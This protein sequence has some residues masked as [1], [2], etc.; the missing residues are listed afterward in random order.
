MNLNKQ[1]TQWWS[2]VNMMLETLKG[3]ELSPEQIEKGMVTHIEEFESKVPG[4][5]VHLDF[6]DQ[7][8]LSLIDCSRDSLRT[9]TGSSGATILRGRILNTRLTAQVALRED[10]VSNDIIVQALRKMADYI[11]KMPVELSS[12]EAMDVFELLG[13]GKNQSAQ[14]DDVAG[15]DEDEIQSDERD[16][17]DQDE[18]QPEPIAQEQAVNDSATMQEPEKEPDESQ[19]SDDEGADQSNPQDKADEASSSADQA[20]ES[21]AVE[22]EESFTEL[23]SMTEEEALQFA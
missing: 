1:Q 6:E 21:K 23:V 8:R 2:V 7:P 12:A 17:E 11:E 13:Q 4:A 16:I 3:L 14:E 20:P 18:K 22:A 9:T 15:S 10:N 5:K 19:V